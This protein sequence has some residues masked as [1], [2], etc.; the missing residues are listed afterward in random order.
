M[1]AH[2]RKT[3]DRAL[4]RAGLFSR[5]AARAAVQA[6]RVTVNGRLVRD[7]DAWVDPARDRLAC[8]GQ[9]VR[10][11]EKRYLMLHKPPGYVTTRS[12]ERGRATVYDLLPSDLPWLAPIGRLDRES[13][14]LLLFTNDSDFADA[15]TD[16]RTHVE[17]TYIARCRGQLDEEACRRL[18]FGVDLADGPTREARVRI[19]GRDSKTTS[20]ELT[21]TEGR[22]R[23]VR[24][25]V[26]AIGSKVLALHRRAIAGIEVA[27][28]AVGAVRALRSAEV[29]SLRDA[30]R[31]RGSSSRSP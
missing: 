19:L 21:I 6:G 11:A 29:R 25:M 1:K 28:L 17:K 30:A 26:A 7:P 16:P 23:Q 22:N 5:S 27:E 14:G 13:S 12:D 15:I 31:R 4:S 20:L 8:D 10:A 18:A 9:A 3:L 2:T 24:R